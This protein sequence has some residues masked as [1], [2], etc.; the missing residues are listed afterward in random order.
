M[1][2]EGEARSDNAGVKPGPIIALIAIAAITVV[3]SLM[4]G[5]GGKKDGESEQ[6]T[7]VTKETNVEA[8][9]Q[10]VEKKKP[11]IPDAAKRLKGRWRRVDG[12]YMIE[13][14][15]VMPG[16]KLDA[17]YFNPHP[18]NVSRAAYSAAGGKVTMFIELRDRNYPGATYE[19]AYDPEQDG[20]V[21]KYTQ[22][23]MRQVFD[24]AF[25]RMSE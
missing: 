12:G 14:R 1:G 23:L 9:K 20:L 24:V 2:K 13:V 3:M 15:E 8:E 25:V 21:G 22:P 19:L 7:E 5:G 6:K 10:K 4:V 17:G 16:G 11:S 18:I